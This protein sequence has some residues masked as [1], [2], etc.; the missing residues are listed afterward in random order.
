MVPSYARIVT[1]FVEEI[2]LCSSE[3]V[4]TG[5]TSSKRTR[6]PLVG[7]GLG[8]GGAIFRKVRLHPRWDKKKHLRSVSSEFCLKLT[9]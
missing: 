6:K 5:C 4:K 9:S 1:S 3:K 2:A 8:G 7:V